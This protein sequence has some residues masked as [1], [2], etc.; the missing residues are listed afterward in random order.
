MKLFFNKNVEV[1]LDYSSKSTMPNNLYLGSLSLSVGEYLGPDEEMKQNSFGSNRGVFAEQD[2]YR[3]SNDSN[4]LVLTYLQMSNEV[5]VKS[6]DLNLDTSERVEIIASSKI[7]FSI[8]SCDDMIYF[9]DADVLFGRYDTSLELTNSQ[10]LYKISDNVSL[11]FND[12]KLCGWILETASETLSTGE[13]IEVIDNDENT[14]NFLERYFLLSN[15]RVYDLMDDEDETVKSEL[16]SLKKELSNC[17]SDR[18]K[19]I[20][21]GV[22]GFLEGYYS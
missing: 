22:N 1:L 8:E 7:N 18:A 3:F 2:V 5:I 9:K 12:N 4:R 21:E 20:L 13:E 15:D 14:S 10:R 16:L 6:G 19:A 17:Y 11:A